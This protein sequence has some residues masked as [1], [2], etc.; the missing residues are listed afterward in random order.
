MLIAIIIPKERTV[1]MF[2]VEYIKA[3]IANGSIGS[4]ISVGVFGLIALFA[5]LGIIF[6]AKRGFSKS[7]I[8]IFTVAAAAVGSFFIVK[9]ILGLIVDYT[10]KVTDGGTKSLEETLYSINSGIEGYL[11]DYLR[12]IFSE[13]HSETAITVLMMIVALVLSPVLFFTVFLLLK[14]ISLLVYNI[15]AGLAGA[16]SYGKGIV[17]TVFGAVVGLLQGVLIS[18]VIIL[19][20]SG[21]CSIAVDAKVPLLEDTDNTNK[22]IETAYSTVIDDLADNPVFELVDKIGGNDLYKDMITVKIGGKETYMGDECIGVVKLATDIIPVAK[23]FDWKEPTAEQRQALENIVIDVGDDGL[24]AS[25]ASDLMRGLAKTV[26]ANKL[27]L[28][29]FGATD[30]LVDDALTMFATSTKDTIEGDL[31]VTLDVYFIMCDRALFHSFTNSEHI[32]M[33]EL[34]TQ[35][36]ENGTTT[37]SVIIKRLNQYDRARPIVTSFTK[38]TLAVMHGSESFGE[39]ATALYEN[40]KGDISN[41]LSHNKSDFETEEEYKEAVTNDVDK[42]LAENNIKL[43]ESVKQDMVDYIADNYGDHEGEITDAEI[44]DALLSYYESY[45][46]SKENAGSEGGTEGGEGDDENA[47]QTYT[48]T[49]VDGDG[50]P[51]EGVKVVLTNGITLSDEIVTDANGKASGSFP[52]GTIS[53]LITELSAE[54]E[55]P[56][57]VSDPYHGVFDSDSTEL[58][59]VVQ[60]KTSDE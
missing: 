10:S 51:V 23:G 49:I 58:T 56:A 1:V 7:V 43:E 17:S 42:A 27:T 9:W 53:V 59:V 50:A 5:L 32:D 16:I 22:Y 54:Y 36:D 12:T 48:V 33:K 14:G 6:G 28:G 55:T 46:K 31:D 25:L 3:S 2:V 47:D 13:V 52:A 26:Q 44:S 38:I 41:A 4:Y 34:L 39:D 20:I 11:P 29:L 57:V 21:V 30:A 60:K 40:V 19:P 35:K 45:A 8:R 37:A 18:A 15:L 24:T